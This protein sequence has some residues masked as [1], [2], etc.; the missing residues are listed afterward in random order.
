M[1]IKIK[2]IS[3]IL[4]ILFFIV[5]IASSSFFYKKYKNEK[6]D[7]QRIEN[8]WKLKND[9]LDFYKTKNGYYVQQLNSQQIKHNELKDINS[10]LYD[11]I[12][13]LKMK[14][15]NAKSITKI[16]TVIQYVNSDT[17]KS[18]STDDEKLN[19]IQRFNITDEWFKISLKI[20][21]S[22]IIPENLK[23]EMYDD[24]IIIS[25]VK[26][27]G[28]WFWRKISKVRINIANKNP[29]VKLNVNHYDIIK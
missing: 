12:K 2:N 8:N 1:F 15:K 10:G 22:I 5:S 28:W 27:K 25:D 23:I 13:D 29:Y 17:I 26:Y 4:I 20:T 19:N 16:K 11:D 24:L 7:R 6:K 14:L 3:T 9:T 21:D 18:E